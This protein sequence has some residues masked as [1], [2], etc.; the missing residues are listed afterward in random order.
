MIA[1]H[2]GFYELYVFDM[3]RHCSKSHVRP[4]F[5]KFGDVAGVNWKSGKL[6]RCFFVEYQRKESALKA[7]KEMESSKSFVVEVSNNSKANNNLM[8]VKNVDRGPKQE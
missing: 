5:S 3:R 1:N 2:R 7:L 4:L 8:A 6:A